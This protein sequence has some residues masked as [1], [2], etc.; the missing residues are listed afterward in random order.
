MVRIIRLLLQDG[1]GLTR[2]VA[3]LCDNIHHTMGSPVPF[4]P[5]I[6]L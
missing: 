6:L 3:I 1:L 4:V 2:Q 5:S